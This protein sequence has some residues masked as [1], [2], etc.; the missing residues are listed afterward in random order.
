MTEPAD[1]RYAV[2]GQV[3]ERAAVLEIALRMAFCALI[4]SPGAAVVADRQEAHWLIENC[5][6]IVRH[7]Q[8]LAA[9][10]RDAIHTALRACREAN[11]DRNRLVH[12][13]WDNG[14]GRGPAVVADGGPHRYRFAG[15]SWSLADIQA[16][17]AAISTA[18]QLLLTALETALG[19]EL[20]AQASRQLTVVAAQRHR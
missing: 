7:H 18:Q 20:L 10:Q 14:P 11:Q 19:T 15:R 1:D 8:D 9:G 2:L 12:E 17:A 13:A 16:A 6:A 4:G 5:E 3:V